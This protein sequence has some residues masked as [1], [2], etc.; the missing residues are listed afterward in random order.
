MY[1]G[2][3]VCE[4]LDVATIDYEGM[5]KDRLYYILHP[6]D[7]KSGKIFTPVDNKKTPMRRIISR[8]EANELIDSISDMGN[9]WIADERMRE[10]SYK[11][12]IKNSDCRQLS[13]II[14]TLYLRKQERVAQGKKITALDER[15]LKLAEDILFSELSFS[16]EI[17]KDEMK[18][19]IEERMGLLALN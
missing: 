7:K 10:K 17:P 15:Y 18:E 9:L 2:T 1:G 11:E 16:L 8:E 4:V 12:C 3:G 6:Y 14:K 13:K 5:P 19:Y